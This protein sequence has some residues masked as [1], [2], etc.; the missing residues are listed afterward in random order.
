MN[1]AGK[2]LALMKNTFGEGWTVL[3]LEYLFNT[4]ARSG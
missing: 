4:V 1:S 2:E 3:Q